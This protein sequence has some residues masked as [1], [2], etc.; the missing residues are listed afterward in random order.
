MSGVV[1]NSSLLAKIGDYGEISYLFYP[2]VGYETHF[3]DSALA[4]LIKRLNG[5]GMM[6]GT[7]TKNTLKKLMHLKPS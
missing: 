5:F 3:F 6:I 2:H 7:S 1:G 4:F